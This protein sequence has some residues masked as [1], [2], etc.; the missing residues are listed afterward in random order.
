MERWV[1]CSACNATKR[2]QEF[3]VSRWGLCQPC[4]ACCDERVRAAKAQVRSA[5]ELIAR[6]RPLEYRR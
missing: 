4:S 6:A 2:R 5:R 3:Y 1:V